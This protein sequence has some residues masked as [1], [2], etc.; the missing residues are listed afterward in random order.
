MTDL[1]A[2]LTTGK[3]SWGHISSL[4]EKGGFDKIFLITNQFGKEKFTPN[5][6][7]ELIVV[8]EQNPVNQLI[9][10]IG[11]KLNGKIRGLEVGLNLVS[12]SG[13]EHMAIISALMKLGVGFRLIALTKDG[14]QEI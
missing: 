11:A 2:C 5:D 9:E 12:G 13:K 6:K 7:T 10:E 3:G 1:V 8:N 4:I 14:V